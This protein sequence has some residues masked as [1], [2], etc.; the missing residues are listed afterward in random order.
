MVESTGDLGQSQFDAHTPYEG[1]DGV[2]GLGMSAVGDDEGRRVAA[3]PFDDELAAG[4]GSGE[5]TV[6]G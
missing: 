3:Q 6:D 4:A 1:F 5:R 2:F